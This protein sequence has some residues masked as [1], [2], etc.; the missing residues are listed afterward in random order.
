[1]WIKTI[2]LY[3]LIVSVHINAIGE[4][5]ELYMPHCYIHATDFSEIETILS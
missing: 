1:M 3:V 2:Y 4:Y 5:L